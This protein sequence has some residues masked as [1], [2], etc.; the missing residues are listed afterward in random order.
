MITPRRD[1]MQI[2]IKIVPFYLLAEDS[3][4]GK[5]F[6][7]RFPLLRTGLTKSFRLR[8]KLVA[9]SESRKR[10]NQYPMSTFVKTLLPESVTRMLYIERWHF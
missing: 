5:I 6:R 9:V 2:N 7:V 4:F 3:S 1:L 10:V 8:Q